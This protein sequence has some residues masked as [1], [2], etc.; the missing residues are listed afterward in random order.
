M[1]SKKPAA[2]RKAA[3]KPGKPL[4]ETTSPTSTTPP[5]SK[6]RVWTLP[7][8]MMMLIVASGGLWLAVHEASNA[9]QAASPSATHAV[10]APEPVVGAS[11]SA[12]AE[13]G[14]PSRN[15]A[16]A[17]AS[18]VKPVSITGCLQHAD[19]GFVLKDAQGAAA[20]KSRSWK[21]GFLKRNAAP[22]DLLDGANA[23]HL[24]SHVGQRVTV[25]GSLTDREMHVQSLRRVAAV[26]Q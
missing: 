11:V 22:I 19:S 2:A 14:S 25:T 21:S 20:P 4:Q 3:A 13:H 12:P 24:G 16:S 10:P 15:E 26:C 23:A 5:A 6:Q 8:A 7:I 1:V 18:Q 17:H 9:P